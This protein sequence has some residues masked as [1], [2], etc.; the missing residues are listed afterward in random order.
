MSIPFNF[1]F[2]FGI[3]EILGLLTLIATVL[4]ILFAWKAYKH[5]TQMIEPWSME[6]VG[7]DL[8]L[9]KRTVPKLAS[10]RGLVRSNASD[11]YE[12]KW[13]N[14]AGH[15]YA[16]FKKGTTI[17]LKITVPFPGTVFQI[18]YQEQKKDL[19]P[20]NPGYSDDTRMGDTQV[21]PKNWKVWEITLY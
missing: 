20:N 11:N 13:L 12:V 7:E 18:Y 17:L 8:W 19:Y 15:P 14:Q 16:C 5:Q 9:L 4:G 21:P 1:V 3:A 2:N 6:K 10:I